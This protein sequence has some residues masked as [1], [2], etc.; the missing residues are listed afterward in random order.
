MPVIRKYLL[1]ILLLAGVLLPDYASGRG[2]SRY[3]RAL[4]DSIVLAQDSLAVQ[5]T[6]AALDSAQLA[7]IAD[8]L[9]LQ[10]VYDSL[11]QIFWH[12]IDTTSLVD[13]DSLTTAYFEELAQRLPDTSDIKR[14]LRRIRKEQRDSVRASIPRVLE[15]YVV[16]DSMYFRRIIVWTSDKRFNEF[17]EQGLDTTANSNFYEQPM[18]KKDISGTWL[19]TNGSAALYHN[20][21]RRQGD[22]NKGVCGRFPQGQADVRLLQ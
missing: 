4:Q 11:D 12:D 3:F 22:G 20:W 19:G 17:T 21:F 18:F 9:R 14:A 7:A 15:T 2:R 6:V 8:S 16:P 1:L 5:D 10:A 13:L